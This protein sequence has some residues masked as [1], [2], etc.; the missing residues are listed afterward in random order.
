MLKLAHA[1]SG[2]RP[3]KS[4]TGD[5]MVL[6]DAAW[7]EIV[8]SEVGKNSHPTRLVNKTLIV[9]TRSSAWSQQLS[10]LADQ[11][12]A[13]LGQRLPNAGIER[14]R[15]RVGTVPQRR[16]PSAPRAQRKPIR[17]PAQRPEPA[18]PAQALERFRHDVEARRDA[19]RSAGWSE[20][21]GCGDLLPPPS[22]RC[23]NCEVAQGEARA[24]E[25]ARLLFE[26]PWLGFSGTAALVEGLKEEEYERIR[27]RLLTRWWDLLVQT[28]DSKRVS[29][30]GRERLIASSYVLLQSKIPPEEIMPATVRSILGD[31]L[32]EVLYGDL[33][34]TSGI[35]RK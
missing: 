23:I 14:L 22:R 11:V 13:A 33:H 4:G 35:E 3:A 12:L 2:W 21:A 20:C 9:T 31:E 26:A 30:N 28:R 10:F 32:H 1:L 16:V 24:A 5:P 7:S 15:F 8:G 29:R 17:P 6:L 25:T 19:E 18:S 27:T 34:R